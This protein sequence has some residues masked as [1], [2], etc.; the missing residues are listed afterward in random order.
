[1]GGT[2]LKNVTPQIH[3]DCDVRQPISVLKNNMQTKVCIINLFYLLYREFIY[4]NRKLN[5][6]D[7]LT[8]PF[9]KSLF[10]VKALT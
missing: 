6:E 7:H 5:L 4:I 8:N 3:R 10:P 1:M 2:G 9:K